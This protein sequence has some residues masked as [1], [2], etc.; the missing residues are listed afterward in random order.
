MPNTR[1]A[2]S[3]RALRVFAYA[4]PVAAQ[5]IMLVVMLLQGQWLFAIMVFAGC[6]GCAATLLITLLRQQPSA[7]PL[8]SSAIAGTGPPQQHQERADEPALHERILPATS[9]EELLGIAGQRDAWRI[10]ARRWLSPAHSLRVPLGVDGH[11]RPAFLDLLEQGPHAIVA[12]TTGSGKSVLLQSW[13]M[14]LAALHPPHA[15][16]FLLLDFKGGSAMNALSTLPH[17]RGCV[18]DLDL[19]H[20]MRALEAIEQELRGRERLAAQQGVADIRD[21]DPR[22]ARMIVVVDEFY[23]MAGQLPDYMDRLIRVA[24]LGRSLGMHVVA[25]T[26]NPLGQINASMKANMSLRVCMRVHDSLQSQEMIGSDHAARLSAKAPGTALCCVDGR[27]TLLRCAFCTDLAYVARQIRYAARLHGWLQPEPLF[28]APLPA[29]ITY[30]RVLREHQSGC[31]PGQSVLIGLA[32]DGVH[33]AP[34]H[35]PVDRGNIAVVGMPGRGRSTLLRHIERLV[36][37]RGWKHVR[38]VDDADEL[39]DVLNTSAC[40]EQFRHDLFDE[41]RTV[42]MALR[43]TKSLRIPEHGTIRVMF[44]CAERSVDLAD[45][46]PSALLNTMTVQD[47]H[48][49]GRAVL[50][51]VGQAR[52]IQCVAPIGDA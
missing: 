26:Q 40:A 12:G 38:V 8:S 41:R 27:E 28:T 6:C 24:S 16:Q 52:V 25:C 1:H 11:K 9:L 33:T 22:P 2:G 48:T 21:M 20:A 43:S 17:T 23:A 34:A 35:V 49:P 3:L 37:E 4:A 29:Q 13:C 51:G 18:S 47:L 14:A 30:E 32:D 15:L 39:L 10:I 7:D 19:Q 42:V 36:R 46:I 50:L 5:A 31:S 45:G 44:P